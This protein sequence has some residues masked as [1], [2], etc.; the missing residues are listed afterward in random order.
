M[1]LLAYVKSPDHS[2][3]FDLHN[4]PKISKAAE[5]AAN[6][7][8]KAVARE[9]ERI[10]VSKSAVSPKLPSPTP[11]KT[12]AQIPELAHLGPIFKSSKAIELT[13]SET[14]YTVSCIKHIFAKYLVFQVILMH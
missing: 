12:L 8:A 6:I 7:K 1:Q 5:H 9:P 3:P 13:E 2:T 10:S 11:A 14:E 4:V